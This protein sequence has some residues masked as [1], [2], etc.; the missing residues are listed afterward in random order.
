MPSADFEAT[1]EKVEQ[2]INNGGITLFTT[3]TCPFCVKAKAAL[4]AAKLKYDFYELGA[5]SQ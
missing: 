2:L 3:R 1:Q 4:D 5:S